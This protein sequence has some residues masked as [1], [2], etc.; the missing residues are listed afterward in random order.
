MASETCFCFRS[1]NAQNWYTSFERPIAPVSLFDKEM[2]NCRDRLIKMHKNKQTNKATFSNLINIDTAPPSAQQR[3]SCSEQIR[4]SVDNAN[5]ISNRKETRRPKPNTG[6]KSADAQERNNCRISRSTFKKNIQN[7]TPIART[8]AKEN[9]KMPALENRISKSEPVRKQSKNHISCFISIGDLKVDTRKSYLSQ[10]KNIPEPRQTTQMIKKRRKH[11]SKSESYTILKPRFK[12]KMTAKS[13]THLPEIQTLS[14]FKME[15]CVKRIKKWHLKPIAPQNL[16]AKNHLKLNARRKR[17]RGCSVDSSDKESGPTN[18]KRA[19]PELMKNHQRDKQGETKKPDTQSKTVST[20]QLY[21]Q[22]KV[23][24]LTR[25][26]LLLYLFGKDS[27]TEEEMP[28]NKT[29]YVKNTCDKGDNKA[30]KTTKPCKPAQPKVVNRN[31]VLADLFPDPTEVLEKAVKSGANKHKSQKAPAC[32]NNTKTKPPFVPAGSN[33]KTASTSDMKLFVAPFPEPSVAKQDKKLAKFQGCPVLPLPEPPAKQK[34]KIMLEEDLCTETCTVNQVVVHFLVKN[35]LI[36]VKEELPEVPLASK[37]FSELKLEEVTF[38]TAHPFSLMPCP[39]E[40]KAI[41]RVEDYRCTEKYNICDIAIV[42]NDVRV[43]KNVTKSDAEFVTLY[44]CGES[45]QNDDDIQIV[46]VSIPASSMPSKKNESVPNVL[47]FSVDM[48]SLGS[49]EITFPAPSSEQTQCGFVPHKITPSVTVPQP[50][51]MEPSLLSIK[52]RKTIED[53]LF[54]HVYFLMHIYNARK[55]YLG[56]LE[57]R[58]CCKAYFQ[59]EIQAF[60]SDKNVRIQLQSLKMRN[61]LLQLG[62]KSSMRSQDA[63]QQIVHSLTEKLYRADTPKRVTKSMVYMCLWTLMSEQ[64]E[65]YASV[66]LFS[67]IFK[68]SDMVVHKVTTRYPVPFPVEMKRVLTE[69]IHKYN[70]LVE[71][72]AE[73]SSL[74]L[75]QRCV[76][77]LDVAN[78][79]KQRTQLLQN[80]I[81]QP[82]KTAANR[83]NLPRNPAS[84]SAQTRV[85]QAAKQAPNSLSKTPPIAN[86][87]FPANDNF[88]IKLPYSRPFSSGGTAS[89]PIMSTAQSHPGQSFGAKENPDRPVVAQGI[90]ALRCIGRAADML[91]YHKTEQKVVNSGVDTQSHA[92]RRNSLQQEKSV[93]SSPTICDVEPASQKDTC[94]EEK[95]RRPSSTSSGNVETIDLTWLDDMDEGELKEQMDYAFVK[96]EDLQQV[97]ALKEVSGSDFLGLMGANR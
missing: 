91:A 48:K 54:N 44:P 62:I 70:Q 53:I 94:S 33:P 66:P 19:K 64:A 39:A 38:E 32:K 81:L 26:E 49:A 46:S 92:S 43:V 11:R 13:L 23:R 20:D 77:V 42:K 88:R 76:S 82:E 51:V 10:Q 67:A 90:E 14:G 22:K 61:E 16:P 85:T 25:T 6:N 89:S 47:S 52:D 80:A 59:W 15:D 58:L 28:S 45:S 30:Q 24:R 87:A 18:P 4:Y 95:S 57:N 8:N 7:Q 83:A 72:T 68:H 93:S 55:A 35:E 17:G 2:A 21:D 84:P 56:C 78:P 37:H 73:M 97:A 31:I 75:L 9:T 63:A 5:K 12:P 40:E 34:A 36:V 41:S 50:C 69:Q 60:E 71:I 27:D 79:P 96:S 29:T 86:F 65:S 3:N 1:C 74:Y